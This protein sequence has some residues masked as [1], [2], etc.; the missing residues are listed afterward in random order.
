MATETLEPTACDKTTS[1]WSACGSCSS[2]ARYHTFDSPSYQSYW[3][4]LV[5]KMDYKVWAFNDDDSTA[6]YTNHTHST[7]RWSCHT[8]SVRGFR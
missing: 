2:G 6:C 5:A 3:T 1:G 4:A 8:R 7:P